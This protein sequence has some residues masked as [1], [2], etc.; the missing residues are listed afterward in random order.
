MKFQKVATIIT[1]FLEIYDSF[2]EWRCNSGQHANVDR[3]NDMPIRIYVALV[4]NK[5]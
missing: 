4:G 1:R 3:E 2:K 5:L